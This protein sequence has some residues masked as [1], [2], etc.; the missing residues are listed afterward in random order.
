MPP[1][2]STRSS[3][4]SS[5]HSSSR[6]AVLSHLK[7][8]TKCGYHV[9]APVICKG[10]SNPTKKGF[11][12]EKCLNNEQP[13]PDS[14]DY[15]K[16][17][18]DIPRGK[19]T[20]R[21]E[22][23]KSQ[24]PG[25]LCTQAG[26]PNAINIEC[27]FGVC[28]Q[29][30]RYIQP[31]L[32]T[33]RACSFIQDIRR[34]SRQSLQVEDE[35]RR[36]RKNSVRLALEAALA[37]VVKTLRRLSSRTPSNPP[38]SAP[39]P[40]QS[41]YAT[42]TGPAYQARISAI[43][44][45]QRLFEEERVKRVRQE[46]AKAHVQVITLRWWTKNGGEPEVV[47]IVVENPS[48]FHPK[49]IPQLVEDYRCD[50]EKFQYYDSKKGLWYTGSKGSAPRDLAKL[51]E[52]DLCYRSLGVAW[53]DGMPGAQKKRPA[54][55]GFAA[56]E[57][58]RRAIAYGVRPP[59]RDFPI[60]PES[61]NRHSVSPVT[62]TPPRSGSSPFAEDERSAFLETPSQPDV[63]FSPLA[64]DWLPYSALNET[65]A[66]IPALFPSEPDY[67]EAL[68]APSTSEPL[69]LTIAPRGRFLWPW[70]YVCD[71]A[72]GFAAMR[73]LEDGSPP[74]PTAK[75]FETVF[76]AK[77]KSSTYS[78]QV[79]AWRDA[80]AVQGERAR[81]INIG[82]A[83]GGEWSRFMNRWRPSKKSN[84]LKAEQE[85]VVTESNYFD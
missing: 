70:K 2:S 38:R 30:C 1:R 71:M 63:S 48:V 11:W 14:C 73:R 49:D 40:K 59:F 41:S 67:A 37:R 18:N 34:K 68:N 57:T 78:E 75:A 19:P 39:P 23:K 35:R 65:L 76:H 69:D 72:E 61:R 55:D 13:V 79:R 80:G 45:E 81:W 54:P 15:F 77:F 27:T 66:P 62:T 4:R 47:E 74:L 12:F 36:Q 84:L 7:A 24:C 50:Q 85:E 16:W 82:R 21:G 51:S 3:T 60:T 5:S 44:A 17:R 33:M 9:G 46:H 31:L 58:P 22:T 56:P 83:E 53:G 10:Q 20:D 52:D 32:P 43:D 29:C 64:Q 8:C 25:P 26:K 42:P 28:V 6:V